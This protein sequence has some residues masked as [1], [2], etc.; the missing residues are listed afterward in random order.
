MTALPTFTNTYFSQANAI[1]NA[2]QIVGYGSRTVG[3][4][5][6]VLYGGGPSLT[7]LG[8]L[9][10]N[11]TIAHGINATGQ[12][13]GQGTHDE[14]LASNATYAEIV[15]SQIGEGAVA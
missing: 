5:Y 13:V 15:E 10:G 3:P 12:V 4:T 9:G 14:L 1:N 6:G 7:D 8:S 2:G 11:T